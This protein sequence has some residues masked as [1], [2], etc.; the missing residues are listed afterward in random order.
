MIRKSILITLAFISFAAYGQQRKQLTL[1]FENFPPYEFCIPANAEGINI[2]KIN[3]VVKR[4]GLKVKYLQAPWTRALY[5]ANMGEVDGIFSLFKTAEREKF[6]IYPS[7]ELS[8][9]QDRLYSLK[10]RNLPRIDYLS[11]LKDYS[12]GVVADNSY[13]KAF[14]SYKDLKRDLSLTHLKQVERLLKGRVDYIVINEQVFNVHIHELKMVL[15]DFE[16][17]PLIV[18]REMLYIA[19]SRKVKDSQWL[20]DQFSKLLAK[21]IGTHSQMIPLDSICQ[22]EDQACCPLP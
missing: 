2:Q 10:R 21:D 9:S 19:F 16:V 5:M 3:R 8:Q 22:T 4:M 13:G 18:N 20:S 11:Q 12:V 17:Q 7:L 6:L 1:V 15:D 14:D